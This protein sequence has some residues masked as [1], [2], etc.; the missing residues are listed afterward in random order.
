[1]WLEKAL[2]DSH[3]NWELARGSKKIKNKYFLLRDITVNFLNIYILYPTR[4]H[5]HPS[6]FTKHN[7]L[8][9]HYHHQIRDQLPSHYFIIYFSPEKTHLINQ[10]VKLKKIKKLPVIKSNHS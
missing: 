2:E 5:P 6:H 4:H 1:M 7:Y 8:K 9:K 3:P 10:S